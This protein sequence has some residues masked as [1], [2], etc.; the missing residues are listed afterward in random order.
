MTP[1]KSIETITKMQTV[2]AYAI[3]LRNKQKSSQLQT[4]LSRNF[5]KSEGEEKCITV[6]K[7]V[8]NKFFRID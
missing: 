7:V 5:Q 8:T 4:N 3:N 2:T 6:K 1:R